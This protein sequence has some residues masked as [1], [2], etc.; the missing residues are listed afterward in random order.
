MHKL[1]IGIAGTGYYVP[2]KVLTNADLEQMVD[3]SDE[4]IRERTGI[5]ERRIA[6]P[7]EPVSEMA[8]RAARSALLSAGVRPEELDVIILATFTA[9]RPLPAGACLLQEKLGNTR[10]GSFD[11]SAACC[12]FIYGLE[13]A[14]KLLTGGRYRTA[15]LVAAEKLSSVTDWE[16]RNTCVLFGDGAG[17]VVIKKGHPHGRIIDCYIGSDGSKADLLSIP[18]GGSARPITHRAIDEKQQFVKMAGREVFK[19]AV[20]EMLNAARMVLKRNNYDT[21]D[22]SWLIPHQANLR[23]IRAAARGLNLPMGKVF[24]NLDRY[25]NI[26]GATI[27]VALAEMDQAGLLKRGDLVM[28]VAFGGGLTWSA[29]LVEW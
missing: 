17:A 3:T 7:D 1:E 24:V 27:P 22:I 5:R 19:L 13:V 15:L 8:V 28:M 29:S 14:H 18:A 23:I 20:N 2:A 9:D 16:D 4:W 26:S 6:A 21:S 10:A 12:G 11:I 25:G